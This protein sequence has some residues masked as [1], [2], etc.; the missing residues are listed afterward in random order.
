MNQLVIEV[1]RAWQSLGKV[2]YGISESEKGSLTLRRSIYI[3]K[4][5]KGLT[6]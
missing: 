1:E 3:S 5:M 4:N 2:K 6:K